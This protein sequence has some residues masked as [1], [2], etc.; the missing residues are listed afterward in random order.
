MSD[1][2]PRSFEISSSQGSYL[3][4]IESISKLEFAPKSI[5]IIDNH[6]AVLNHVDTSH[7][8]HVL[9]LRADE[10]LK[11]FF[12]CVDILEDLAQKG[13]QRDNIVYAIGG[14]IVQ[15]ISTITTSLYMRGLAW[16]YVPTT[17]VSMLDSC[18]GGKSSINLGKF[19]NIIGNFYPPK[20]IQIDCSFVNSLSSIDISSGVSEGFKITYAKS[21]EVFKQFSDSVS[22]WR[23]TK[24]SQHLERAIS[25]SL[26]AKKWFIEVD[27]YDKKE[28]RLLNF[29]H[30]FGHA[31]E[32]ASN[33]AVP[34][35]IAVL[36][37]MK[38]AIYESG[39]LE[40]C[41]KLLDCLEGELYISNFGPPNLQISKSQFLTALARDKKNFDSSQVLVLP[42]ESGKLETV[43]RPLTESNL[44][45]CW[46]SLIKSVEQSEV[47]FEVL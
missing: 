33:Y 39:N 6:T 25:L 43:V 10:S 8:S 4:N 29:G 32:S 3:V 28:R 14:G 13:V 41:R 22:K 18:I 15:D 40:T 37:G 34:H 38:A 27:E 36:Y 26:L 2:F 12:S 16:I 17:L 9:F 30:S 46:N 20:R 5:A 23:M 45:S 1:C 47:I 35:G 24:A 42:D 21:P 11:N 31:L 44:E 7:F 19:K